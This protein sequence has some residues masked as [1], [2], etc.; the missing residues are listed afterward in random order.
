MSILLNL[1][2]ITAFVDI[3]HINGILKIK[4]I[5]NEKSKCDE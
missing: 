1:I 2:V 5:H 4:F 3:I